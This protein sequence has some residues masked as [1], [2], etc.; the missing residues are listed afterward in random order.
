MNNNSLIPTEEELSSYNMV[1]QSAAESPYWKKM[2][3]MPAILSVMLMGRELGISPMN[4]ISGMFHVIQGQ[5]EISGRGMSYLIRKKGHILKLIELN[6]HKCTLMGKRIDTGE[7]Q[8]CSFTIEEARASGLIRTG[9]MWTKLP[10]DMLYWR[11]LSRLARRLFTDCLGT[12]YIEGEIREMKKKEVLTTIEPA[13]LENIEIEEID[14]EIPED[15][16]ESDLNNYIKE[17]CDVYDKSHRE[18]KERAKKNLKEF[19]EKVR[20]FN[21]VG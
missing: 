13:D 4:A 18:I 17:L 1:A 16:T 2:G 21:S 19:W 20:E 12:C 8:E 10:K 6:E 11:S 14:M 3:G 9:S 5:V 7:E 15:L